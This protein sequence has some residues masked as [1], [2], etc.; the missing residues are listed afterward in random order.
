MTIR[1]MKETS[2]DW[3][4]AYKLDG[5]KRGKTGVK[6]VEI[7]HMQLT[8]GL[9]RVCVWGADDTGMEIDMKSGAK[10]LRIFMQ[11]LALEDVTKKALRELGFGPA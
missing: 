6:L 3:Y 10:A 5:Y 7:S 11:V 9:Y 1:V 8:S 4:P 2:D